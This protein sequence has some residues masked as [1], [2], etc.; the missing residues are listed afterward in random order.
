MTKNMLIILSCAALLSIST[1]V[2]GAEGLYIS[3]NIGLA[4]PTD[5][6]TEDSTEPGESFVFELDSGLAF[7]M[8]AGYDFGNNVRVEG[9]IAYQKNDLDRA[10]LGGESA[11]L[12]GDISGLGF[13]LNGYYDFVNESVFTPFITGGLGF[14]KVDVNDFKIVISDDPPESHDDTVFAYQ[15]GA[16]VGYAFNEKVTFDVKYRYYGTSDPEFETV[17]AEYSSHNFYAGVRF[18]F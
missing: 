14:T 13:L 5:M 2:Y 7:G 9:E 8:A 1:F 16:G 10:T 11:G 12:T 6:D 17:T 15:I 3:G 18:S 4:M